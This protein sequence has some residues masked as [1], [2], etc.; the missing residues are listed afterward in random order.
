[1]KNQIIRILSLAGASLLAAV[2]IH[3][4]DTTAPSTD[5][6]AR[7]ERREDMREHFQKISKQLNLSE[8]QK[9]KAE[10]IFKQSAESRKAIEA[11]TTLSEEQKHAKMHDLRKSTE[12]QVHGLLTPDQMA[13]MKELRAQHRQQHGDQ[14]PAGQPAPQT[15]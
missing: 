6:P 8:D 9:A 14:P 1:M 2:S 12:E 3:A 10:V 13:K 4:A 11:D 7:H 15:N 5:R